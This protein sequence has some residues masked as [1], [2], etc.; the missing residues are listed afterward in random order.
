MS[1]K[2][3]LSIVIPAYNEEENIAFTL[4][5]I[6]EY[7]KG[8]DFTYE[9]TVVDDGSEDATLHVPP[10]LERNATFVVPSLR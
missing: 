6:T 2:V 8:K 9:V 4:S 3:H 7:L 1:E 5:K 10:S